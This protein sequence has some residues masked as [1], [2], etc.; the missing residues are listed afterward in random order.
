MASTLE[1]LVGRMAGDTLVALDPNCRPERHRGRRRLSWPTRPP[2]RPH[3][4][5]EGKCG[6][7]SLD[8]EPGA[9]PVTA[10]RGLLAQDHA[11]ALL[12]LGSEGAHMITRHAAIAVRARQV[13][14]VDSIGAG[15]AFMGAFLADWRR[16]GLGRGDLG[17]LDELEQAVTFACRVAAI[18]CAR[19]GADPPRLA[20]L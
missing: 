18:T 6:R 2:A 7:P 11:V 13:D 17:R 5:D 12:T 9:D 19:A 10:A 16:R 15:D 8:R 3:R 20:E 1:A 4:R 14:V